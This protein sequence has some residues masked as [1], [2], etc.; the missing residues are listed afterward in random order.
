MLN[1]QILEYVKNEAAKGVSKEAISGALLKAGWQANDINAALA[2]LE[3]GE[4]APVVAAAIQTST[5]V[6]AAEP[7]TPP[8]GTAPGAPSSVTPIPL[9]PEA[10]V[11]SMA[12]ASSPAPVPSAQPAKPFMGIPS[13]SQAVSAELAPLQTSSASSKPSKLPGV[14]AL[15]GAGIAIYRK[16]FTAVVSIALLQVAPVIVIALASYLIPKTQLPALIQSNGSILIGAFVVGVVCLFAFV[17]YELWM[18]L[19]LMHAIRGHDKAIHVGEALKRARPR[20]WSLCFIGFET[21]FVLLGAFMFFSLLPAALIFVGGTLAFPSK[22]EGLISVG[23]PAFTPGPQL[24]LGGI[25]GLIGLLF[26]LIA[27][28]TWLSQANWL[29]VDKD[30]RG[31]H[32]LSGSKSLVKGHFGAVFGRTFGISFIAFLVPLLIGI[33]IGIPLAFA[34]KAAAQ[35]IPGTILG[36]FAQGISFLVIVPIILAASYA[37][38]ASLTSGATIQADK[39]RK[40]LLALAILGVLALIALPIA[41]I[42]L[43]QVVEAPLMALN[44]RSAAIEDANALALINATSTNGVPKELAALSLNDVK[45]AKEFGS[46]YLSLGFYANRHEGTFPAALG[47]LTT[48]DAWHAP[49]MFLSDPATGAPYAYTVA[50]NGKSYQLCA[51]LDSGSQYCITNADYQP[52]AGAAASSS[53]NAIPAPVAAQ[54]IHDLTR[55]EELKQIQLALSLYFDANES[56]Y[57]PSLEALTQPSGGYSHFIVSSALSDPVTQKP[58]SYTANAD[59]KSYKVCAILDSGSQSCVTN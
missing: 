18:S 17:W 3:V 15:V 51:M 45:R 47:A 44:I 39:G 50:A 25:V 24:I 59:G 12:P 31:T 38:Y 34:G 23:I 54:S 40:G 11:S 21:L 5:P 46:L 22:L 48:I 33:V 37:L 49:A 36:I 4:R 57:P 28:T 30:L 6:E 27:F 29:L 55:S 42:A 32:A 13:L 16:R 53:A 35:G 2:A 56:T 41:G 58:Y 8:Q 10:A 43:Y 14:F 1:Q 26:S 19:A 9:T 52:P 20:A 7:V